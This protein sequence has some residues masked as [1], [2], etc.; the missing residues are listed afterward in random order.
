MD[1]S[2]KDS[3]ARHDRYFRHPSN[4]YDCG[5]ST[6]VSSSAPFSYCCEVLFPIGT[7]R[8]S[9]LTSLNI[10]S[11]GSKENIVWECNN[12]G[13]LWPGAAASD[14]STP[15]TTIPNGLCGT[16]LNAAFIIALVIDL[17]CQVRVTISHLPVRSDG[18]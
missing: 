13:Q 2:S 1:T 11:V 5:A 15:T 10:T 4:S 18:K 14:G 9:F 6:R 3:L 16:G 8:S 17:F 7:Y 12:G